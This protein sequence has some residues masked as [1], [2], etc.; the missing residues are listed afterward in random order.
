MI[1]RDTPEKVLAMLSELQL[2]QEERQGW[3][4]FGP[5]PPGIYAVNEPEYTLTNSKSELN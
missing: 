4:S 1:T 2:E 5:E 3:L